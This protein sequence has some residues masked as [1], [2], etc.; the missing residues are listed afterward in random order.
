MLAWD[1]GKSSHVTSRERGVWEVFSCLCMGCDLDRIVSLD[2]SVLLFYCLGIAVTKHL[3]CGFF[4]IYYLQFSPSKLLGCLSIFT[5]SLFSFL[6]VYKPLEG[7]LCHQSC[8][9]CPQQ[10]AHRYP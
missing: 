2:G 5:V 6:V 10:S 4:R 8:C 3:Q 7:H 1:P 9:L